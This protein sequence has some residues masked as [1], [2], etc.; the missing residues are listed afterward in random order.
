MDQKNFPLWGLPS[1]RTQVQE[2]PQEE[3]LGSHQ[4]TA[5]LWLGSYA[6]RIGGGLKAS[7]SRWGQ[8][9]ITGPEK[10]WQSVEV[11]WE[12]WTALWGQQGLLQTRQSLL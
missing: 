9:S 1:L 4:E 6:L 11:F 10:Y 8:V 12:R 5:A 2:S 7:R 3:G